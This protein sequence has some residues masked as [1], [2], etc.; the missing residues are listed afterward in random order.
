MK[1]ALITGTS[2][3]IGRALAE[4]LLAEGWEVF[5]ISRSE[6]VIENSLYMHFSVDLSDLCKLP[7]RLQEIDREMGTL[8][9]LIL[10]AGRGL[11]GQVE[12]HSHR[13][14]VETF[15]LNVLANFYVVKAL[16]PRM[17]R[18]K[19]GRIVF[20][21]S[22]AAHKGK[23]NG[24]VYCASKAALRSFSQS[25]YEEVSSLGIGVTSVHPGVVDTPFFDALSIQPDVG[26]DTALQAG[27]VANVI[28]N[29]L[30]MPERCLV[31]EINL[32]AP[33]QRVVRKE[34]VKSD[35]LVG[36]DRD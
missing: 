9:A 1:K 7:G 20:L 2:K 5:G 11:I 29:L 14:M 28:F 23:R 35:K 13:E 27:D 6:A 12:Q 10:S 36:A 33:H 26:K 30:S 18:A 19:K 15:H 21:G 8:D 25:L 3:G 17:R 22:E 16:L 24:S 4:R 32:A 34:Y 31:E